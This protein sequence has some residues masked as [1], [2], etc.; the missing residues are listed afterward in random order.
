MHSGGKYI[1]EEW[2]QV[3]LR[4]GGTE[5]NLKK[6][7]TP[8]PPKLLLYY[9]LPGTWSLSHP[10]NCRKGKQENLDL[11]TS[12]RAAERGTTLKKKELTENRILNSKITSATWIKKYW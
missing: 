9:T 3:K 2:V 1:W 8:P 7:S 5:Y 4:T 11:G 12:G 10:K 6:Q